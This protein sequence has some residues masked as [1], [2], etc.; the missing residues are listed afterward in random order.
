[1]A[2]GRRGISVKKIARDFGV[3]LTSF[4]NEVMALICGL[5]AEDASV[6]IA[7]RRRETCGAL[8]AAILLSLDASALRSDQAKALSP[9]LFG[10]L[11]STFKRHWSAIDDEQLRTRARKYLDCHD[12]R[13]QVRTASRIVTCLFDTIEATEPARRR[14]AKRLAALIG[15]RMLGD[16]HRLNDFKMNVG[17]QLSLMTLL[18]WSAQLE[19]EWMSRACASLCS[20]RSSSS[21]I[22]SAIIAP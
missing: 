1:M 12:A 21:T 19:G 16:I 5:A 22:S 14:F 20:A 13:S 4:I 7:E 3:D 2:A 9:L 17:I 18:L 6:S 11:E 10:C 8:W 15:H